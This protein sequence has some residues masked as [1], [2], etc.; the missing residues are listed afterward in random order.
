MPVR[1]TRKSDGSAFTFIR[2]DGSVT[3]SR[4]RDSG[5]FA[6]HDLMHY[7][8]ESVLGFTRGFLGLLSAGHEIGEWEDAGSALR[9]DPPVE[10]MHAETLVGMLHLKASTDGIDALAGASEE[11]NGHLRTYFAGGGTPTTPLL[12]EQT[13]AIADLYQDLLTR[14]RGVPVGGAME[15]PWPA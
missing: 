10:A 2:D 11:I 9:R 4:A 8:V 15:L 1:L 5:F 12:P 13:R 7:A 14:W 3:T 6:T